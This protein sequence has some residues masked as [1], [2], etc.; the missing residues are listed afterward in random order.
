M[1]IRPRGPMPPNSTE[2]TVSP[3]ALFT[4]EPV[5]VLVTNFGHI[6]IRHP[7]GVE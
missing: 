3:S 4:T 5:N 7:T 6:Y 1:E 2:A